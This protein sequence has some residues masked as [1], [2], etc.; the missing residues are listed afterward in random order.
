MVGWL[1]GWLVFVLS[2]AGKADGFFVTMVFGDGS[3]LLWA[4]GL[5]LLHGDI[6]VERESQHKANGIGANGVLLRGSGFYITLR[7]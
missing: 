5:L 1:A 3:F 6:R 7:A 2:Q 4:Q